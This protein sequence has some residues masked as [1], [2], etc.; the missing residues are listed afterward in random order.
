MCERLYKQQGKPSYY[1][2]LQNNDK[3][4]EFKENFQVLGIYVQ[5]I[6]LAD[7]LGYSFVRDFF[8]LVDKFGGIKLILKNKNCIIS[9]AEKILG[10]SEYS[11]RENNN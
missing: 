1:R 6:H 5:Y 8:V 7:Y 3:E 2:I 10:Q 9:E 11:K 4:N